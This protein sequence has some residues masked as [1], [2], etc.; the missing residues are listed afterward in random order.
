MHQLEIWVLPGQPLKQSEWLK[1]GYNSLADYIEKQIE[2]HA[3]HQKKS[4]AKCA[5][6]S[7][8]PLVAFGM[9]REEEENKIV[10][11]CKTEK[12]LPTQDIEGVLIFD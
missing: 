4:C 9:L 12:D 7:R 5:K 6:L 11:V 3:E 1:Q 8:L 2:G 10:L